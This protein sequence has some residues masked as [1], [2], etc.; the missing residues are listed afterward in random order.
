ME[1]PRL[2]KCETSD[3]LQLMVKL[4]YV[5]LISVKSKKL[6][7]MEAPLYRMRWALGRLWNDQR[8]IFHCDL[9]TPLSQLSI[10]F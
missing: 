6:K 7:N 8:P 2:W 5:F 10:R 3:K 4:L 9:F 1:S